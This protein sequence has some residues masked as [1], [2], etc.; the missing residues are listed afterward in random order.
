[1]RQYTRNYN[2]MERAELKSL[3][4]IDTQR[5]YNRVSEESISGVKAMGVRMQLRNQ[6][7]Y[8][9]NLSSSKE[10]FAT[11]ES[12]LDTI[13]DKIYV[14]YEA[15]IVA[16]TNGTHDQME[17][18]I[19]AIN[20]EKVAD[21]MVHVLNADFSER[22]IFGGTNNSTPPFRIED[23]VIMTGPDG[24]VAYPPNWEEYYDQV[25]D[26]EGN[27]SY[28]IKKDE[29]GENIDIPKTIT[30]NGIPLNF[31]VIENKDLQSGKYT[32]SVIDTVSGE[33]TDKTFSLDFTAARAK[34]DN[35]LIYP[36][37][38]PILVD[39]GIGIKY[40]SEGNVDP[41]TALDT[42]INGAKITGSGFDSDGFSKN[43]VQLVLDSAYY[44]KL[45][46][47]GSAN[48]IIDKASQANSHILN[49]ITTLG[50]KQNDIDFYLERTEVYEISLKERQ[51]MVEGTDM[52]T[53]ITHYENL[54]AA[55]DA[56]LKLSSETLPHSIFDFI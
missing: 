19:Y 43:L 46:D 4:R 3:T 56:S 32:V 51:N 16:A 11:A 39:I 28:Q 53:E 34:N 55:F 44:L 10:L 45:G 18:D 33:W 47:Q 25:T 15:D 13:A 31:D 23:Q 2:R 36:G 49:E 40:D 42:A 29:N 41:Q 48:A 8:K 30:Y 37:S 26:A 27:I 9:D 50:T 12:N 24:N 5:R 1:M 20:F 17:L 52:N 21:E 22:K 14:Q 6:Q 7:I 54:K 38:K 35:S